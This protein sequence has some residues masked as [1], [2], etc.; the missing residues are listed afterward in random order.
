MDSN[1]AFTAAIDA[2][3]R[4]PVSIAGRMPQVDGTTL[5]ILCAY[6]REDAGA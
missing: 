2:S 5:F 1:S 3:E 6:P 4:L